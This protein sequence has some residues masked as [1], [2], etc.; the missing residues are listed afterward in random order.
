MRRFCLP[1]LFDVLKWTSVNALLG[2]LNIIEMGLFSGGEQIL[3]FLTR[4]RSLLNRAT[5]CENYGGH[6]CNAQ[7]NF[8][9]HKNQFAV[10]KN[11]FSWL[12]KI[13]CKANDPF[14]KKLQLLYIL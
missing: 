11:I 3:T 6:I 10:H 1:F 4:W 5:T 13:Q 7:I 14:L 8:S 9:V 12:R 2:L